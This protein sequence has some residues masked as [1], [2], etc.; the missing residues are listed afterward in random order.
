MRRFSGGYDYFREKIAQEAAGNTGA[1]VETGKTVDE[2]KAARAEAHRDRKVLKNELRRGVREVEALE[3]EIP[4]FEREH[5]ILHERV[6]V[7]ETA[8]DE[9]AP[10]GRRLKEVEE[11]LRTKLAAWEVAG[12]RRDELSKQL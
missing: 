9:R 12:S 1:G 10:A 6:A 7:L 2:A 8:E 3:K 4:G 11:A 5:A